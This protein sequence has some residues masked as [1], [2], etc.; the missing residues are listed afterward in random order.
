LIAWWL[1][2]KLLVGLKEM[3]VVMLLCWHLLA[4]GHEVSI[5]EEEYPLELLERA[6]V[7]LDTVSRDV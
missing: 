6:I 2:E 4:V 3:F 5:N 1:E 7:L